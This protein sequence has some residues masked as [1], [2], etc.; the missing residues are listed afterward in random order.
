[1][2]ATEWGRRSLA[3]AALRLRP[4]LATGLALAA[5]RGARRRDGW[6]VCLECRWERPGGRPAAARL[7]RGRGRA[8]ASPRWLPGDPRLAACVRL[9]LAAALAEVAQET[10]LGLRVCRWEVSRPGRGPRDAAPPGAARRASG[11]RG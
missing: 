2:D 3:R 6:T 4:R 8:Y 11:G 1:M 10:G 5:C 9:A 7:V